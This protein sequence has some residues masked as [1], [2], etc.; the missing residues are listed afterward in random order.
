MKSVYL[1]ISKP[2]LSVTIL[3]CFSFASFSQTT[4]W[5][6]TF[7]NG[8]ASNCI[9][10]TYG[11][12]T[13]LDNVDGTT[14]GA[15]NNWF[16]SCAEEGILPPG[17]GSS[18]I[19]N[20]SLHIG[21]NPGAGGDMGASFNETGATNATFRLAVSPTINTTGN[22]TITLK[23]NFIAFGS[24]ACLDD[25]AQLRLS[26][27]NGATWPVGYQYCLTSVCCGACNGYS[28][29][30][31]TTYTLALP[32]AFD[33][34]PN[35]RVGFHWRNNGN[36][37]GTDPSVAIDNITL[38]AVT[39]LPATLVR[40]QASKETGKVKLNWASTLESQLSHYEVERSVGYASFSKIG[41]VT[42][43]GNNQAGQINYIYN[44]AELFSKP[45][46]YRL[47]MV[48]NDGRSSYSNV[49]RVGASTINEDIIIVSANAR[50]SKMQTAIWA[51]YNV[52]A[53]ISVYDLQGKKIATFP[54]SKLVTGENRLDLNLPKLSSGYYTIKV[55]TSNTSQRNPVKVTKK[56][57]YGK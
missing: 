31:W 17:C 23:F 30:Q 6:E 3:I 35:V 7:N 15:P 5:T 32:A 42:A 33:N 19:G 52:N 49:A 38:A 39:V 20:A 8:C 47:K 26:T 27:D 28:Q 1:L 11:G 21:A 22:S 25:R 36:G 9:A 54:D 2:F 46:Y 16:V 34:N 50:D 55:E 37:S 13:I 40:F 51:G 29:G 4:F 10:S 18:C 48:N 41:S 45:V 14:G 12:W 43:T 57:L 24:S 53:T 44:D 56:F